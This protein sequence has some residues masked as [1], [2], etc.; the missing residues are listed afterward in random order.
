MKRILLLHTVQV[1]YL[2]F[3]KRLR[4]ALS[5]EV[6]I[7]NMLDTFFANNANELGGEFTQN[8]LNRLYLELKAAEMTGADVIAIICSTL[9]PPARQ[10]IP[11]IKTPVVLIDQRLGETAISHGDNIM[12]LASAQ[13][14]AGPTAAL[15]EEAARKAG[16]KVNIEQRH[17]LKAFHAMM[18]ADMET[19]DA[20]I[21]RMAS[22]V[23][24]KDVIVYA[25][26]SMEHTAQAASQASGLP[27]VTAPALCI[28]Q[29]KE[30]I[31]R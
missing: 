5:S 24:G 15:V 11:F 22:E 7:D 3:E 16:R 12:V 28:Q 2:T 8:N 31:D 9:S 10:V 25:Q 14:A 27:V 21:I 4:E 19:H 20:E 1:M 17:N 29:I 23:K 30:L 6:K 26:G 13:S 18:A